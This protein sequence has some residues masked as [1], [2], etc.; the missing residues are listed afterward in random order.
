MKSLQLIFSNPRYLAPALVFTSLNIWF[1]MWAI[2]IPSVKDALGLDK[3]SLGFALF[4]LSFGVFS[5]VP[6]AANIIGKLGVGK[7][8]WL[9]IILGCSAALL[10]LIAPNYWW[11][12]A[13]LYV[14]GFTQGLTDIAMNTLV[15]EIEK[16]DQ[17][18][19]MA[20]AHGFFSLGG[21]IVGAS[22][23]LIPFFNN[24]FL[25]MLLMV[26]LVLWVNFFTKKH[27]IGITAP[28]E[29]KEPFNIK[30][31]KPLFWLGLIGFVSMASEGAIVDWSGL[32]LKEVTIAP[33]ALLG[34]GFLAFSIAMTLG[35]FLGDGL[36]VKLG[37]L[38]TIGFGAVVAV[39]G[40]VL[41]LTGNTYLAVIGFF[42]NGL[43]FSVM[44]P[45]LFRVGGKVHGIAAA[46]GVAFIAG[47]GYSG[48]LLGPVIL[49]YIAE[50]FSLQ[51]SF[52]VLLLAAALIALL[53]IFL[54]Y[55]RKT[56]QL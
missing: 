13:S 44:V 16:Q 34:S 50:H 38:K 4:F 24:P 43:G 30:L 41:V 39:F 5:T 51:R 48:F 3:A 31:F 47:A 6:L 33:T 18:S 17:K 56:T 20:A 12:C 53:T 46:Q 28:P 15:A 21:I 42:C 45:E 10:P 49:G 23:F 11:L 19:F 54:R 2:Y 1:G 37:S 32:Y 25:H 52:L 22:S 7:A 40:Y 8:T 14:F 9:G 35:R 55:K 36:Q 27:F 26:S 29:T